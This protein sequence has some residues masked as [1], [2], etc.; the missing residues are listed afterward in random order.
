MTDAAPTDP[1]DHEQGELAEVLQEVRRIEV[2]SDRL[3]SSVMAGS[4]SSVFRGAGVE[5]DEVREFVEG[6]DPR[7]I[8]WSVTARQGRPFVKKYVDERELTILFA[9]DL[10]ASMNGGFGIWSA[11]QMAVRVCACLGFSA[12]RNH[13]KVG[14]LTFS[15][16]VDSYT[17]AK[18][19]RGHALRIVRDGLLARAGGSQGA[20]EPML[21]FVSR[22]TRRRSVLFV[23]SDFFG[24]R[25]SKELSRCARRHDVVA[26]RMLSPELFPPET[27]MVRLRDPETGAVT[28]VDWQSARVREAYAQRVA[29]WRDFT[30]AELERCGADLMD[31]PVPVR[32]DKDAVARPIL[33]FFRMRQERGMKR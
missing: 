23:L 9:L 20:F 6:D 16:D 3:V 1:H 17:P 26:V 2:Q 30:A 4:Y 19:G 5:F 18:K 25:G 14:L 21:S 10:S 28:L 22:V 32:F 33:E 24:F 12:V 11:R 13:D 15:G 7:L 27:G 31:V 8:D 29:A